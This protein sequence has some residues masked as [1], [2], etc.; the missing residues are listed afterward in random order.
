[1]LRALFISILM[2]FWGAAAMAQTVEDILQ[3][4][5]D[6][7]QM[8]QDGE[9]RDAFLAYAADTAIMMN[10]GQHFVEGEG[11]AHA[12]IGSWP[13]G[14]NLSWAPIGGMLA[15]SGELGFTYG[16]YVSLSSDEEGNEI[17]SHGKYVTIG[18]RQEDGSWKWVLDGGNPSPT[19]EE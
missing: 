19:P 9:V 12:F 1:M 14:I 18:Q 10:P 13:D 7:N 4:E 5:R 16:T 8:A 11:A 3:A 2:T 17:A 15:E 6:F